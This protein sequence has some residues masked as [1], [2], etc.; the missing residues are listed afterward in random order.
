MQDARKDLLQ[1]DF[2]GI[3]KYFRVTMPK[4]YME[5]ERYKQ[6]LASAL[7]IKVNNYKNNIINEN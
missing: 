6:L 1:M 2:E 5:E 3:L 4:R 7:S